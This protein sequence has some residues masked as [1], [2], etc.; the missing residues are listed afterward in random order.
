[1]KVGVLD[2]D[3]HNFPNLALMK[4]SAKHKE[5]GDRVEWYDL[6]SGLDTEYDIV[7][8]SKVFDDSYTQDYQYH[9]Y[10]KKIVRGGYGYDHYQMPFANYEKTFPDYSIYRDIYPQY[11]KSAIGYLTRGCPRNCDFCMVSKYEG[12]I[13]RQ[14]ASVD[15]FFDAEKHSEIRLLDPNILAHQNLKP[16]IQLKNSQAKIHFTGGNDIRFLTKKQADIINEMRDVMLHFAWDLD[17]G[18]TEN[19]LARKRSWI[20]Y[21]NRRVRV[22]VLTNF[23]TTWEFDMYRI[24]RLKQLDYDPYVMIYDKPN[25]KPKYKHLQRA[26]NNKYIFWSEKSGIKNILDYLSERVVDL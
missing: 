1:M 19:E 24:E 13:T 20:D 8:A 26:V 10:A 7:Y 25:A 12:K 9:I 16:L 5:C 21:D 15:D 23:N 6:L 22:Y 17:D 2:V 3:S 14:V 4:L 18:I 11:R